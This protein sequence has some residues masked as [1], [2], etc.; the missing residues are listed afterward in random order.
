MKIEH[1]LS[2]LD[3]LRKSGNGFMS[4]C[5]AHEDSDPSL[6]I[7]DGGDRVLIH[8]FAGCSA[9]DVLTAIG[10]DWTDAFESMTP[11]Q[12][13]IRRLTERDIKGFAHSLHEHIGNVRHADVAC[14]DEQKRLVEQSRVRLMRFAEK[15]GGPALQA[16]LVLNK[17]IY[18]EVTA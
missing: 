15:Y 12:E 8:C 14:T 4:K 5:P 13:T 3:G 7:S 2:R 1:V 9:I 16:V 11:Q 18:D 10:L 6:R 17:K